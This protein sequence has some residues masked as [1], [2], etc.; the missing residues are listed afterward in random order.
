MTAEKLMSL[1]VTDLRALAERHGVSGHARMRKDQLI[2]A[3][4]PV[5]AAGSPIQNNAK[6]NAAAKVTMPVAAGSSSSSSRPSPGPSPASNPSAPG[7]NP[8]LPIPERYGSDRLVLLMQDAHHIFAYWEITPE[9]FAR[10][11]AKA[12]ANAAH[13]L[14]LHAPSGLEQRD[15]DLRGGNYYLSVAPG[16]TYRAEISLR[17]KDGVL[18][19]LAVS[20]F[21]QT[22]LAGPSPRSDAQWLGIDE[23]FHE[24]LALA[25]LPGHEPVGSLARL[26]ARAGEGHLIRAESGG[27]SGFSSTARTSSLLSKRPDG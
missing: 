7:P 20:N 4:L 11:A 17:S 1:N 3:L 22:P 24:L 6:G 16:A 25:G 27:S 23:T 5:I 18:H 12:G 13:V 2:G 21:V 26:Q 15:I 19:P 9:T 8:G 14:I 10:V